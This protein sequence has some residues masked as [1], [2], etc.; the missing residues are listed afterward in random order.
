MGFLSSIKDSLGNKLGLLKDQDP[1][2]LPISPPMSESKSILPE[3]CE[4]FVKERKISTSGEDYDVYFEEDKPFLKVRGSMLSHI[5][6]IDELKIYLHE[7]EDDAEPKQVAKLKRKDGGIVLYRDTEAYF[8]SE[9][10]CWIYQVD[11][12]NFNVYKDE[13]KENLIYTFSGEFI[14]RDIIMKNKDD[15]P[16]AKIDERTFTEARIMDTAA[17]AAGYDVDCVGLDDVQSYDVKI[18]KGMDAVLALACTVAIDEQFD[19][20]RAEKRKEKE[21]D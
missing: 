2:D 11:D 16:V 13:D 15:E 12:E 17:E 14:G 8:D 5:P 9:K 4:F 20:V 10:V 1:S 7:D 18:A 3:E 6:G 21:D 19:E